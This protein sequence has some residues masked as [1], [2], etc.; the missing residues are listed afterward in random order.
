MYKSNTWISLN[1][2]RDSYTIF[3]TD[4]L[5]LIIYITA[6]TFLLIGCSDV[7]RNL[8]VVEN[9]SDIDLTQLDLVRENLNGFW[10][11]EDYI[12]G[13][14]ILWLDFNQINNV[15]IWQTI[16]YSKRIKRPE[17]LPYIS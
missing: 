9:D 7:K 5:R 17:E 10:I 2:S 1:H 15:S 12:D 11:I 13:K 3:K 4:N 8:V 16:P 6:L 14:M